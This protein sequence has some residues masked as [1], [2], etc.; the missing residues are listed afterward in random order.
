M[1]DQLGGEGVSEDIYSGSYE[2]S[3]LPTEH[4]FLFFGDTTRPTKSAQQR[5]IWEKNPDNKVYYANYIRQLV[6]DYLD[7][8]ESVSIDE[9]EKEIRQ[10]D[11]SDPEYALY[12]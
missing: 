1:F 12:Y 10:G 11:G 4:Q 6:G 5:A 3:F 9:L 7:E 2:K 8:E